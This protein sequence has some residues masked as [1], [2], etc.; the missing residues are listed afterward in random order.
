MLGL[1]IRCTQY[2]NPPLSLSH[3][4]IHL[5]TQTY[6]RP[7][8]HASPAAHARRGAAHATLTLSSHGAL[9]QSSHSANRILAHPVTYTCSIR[10]H[11]SRPPLSITPSTPICPGGQPRTQTLMPQH[12][13]VKAQTEAG[14][15]LSL[16][17]RNQEKWPG[18][19]ARAH[20]TPSKPDKGRFRPSTHTQGARSAWLHSAGPIYGIQKHD[21]TVPRISPCRQ[22]T[23]VPRSREKGLSPS[24]V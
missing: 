1:G 7:W 23:S 11:R 16:G 22:V 10:L 21:Q 4:S 12:A 9:K 24:T 13:R 17:T 2:A 8:F 18:N 3:L 19:P 15:A 6:S 14:Q 20:T 5:A